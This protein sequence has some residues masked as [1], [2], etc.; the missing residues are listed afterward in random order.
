MQS[1]IDNDNEFSSEFAQLIEARKKMVKKTKRT[2]SEQMPSFLAGKK[3]K[4]TENKMTSTKR[5]RME[6]TVEQ[7]ETL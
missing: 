1:K 6:K 5:K 4:K 2:V 3:S 7:E